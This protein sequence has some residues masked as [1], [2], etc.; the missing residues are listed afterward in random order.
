MT[1]PS[2]DEA[3]LCG[4]PFD[5]AGLCGPPFDGAGLSVPL[6]GERSLTVARPAFRPGARTPRRVHGGGIEPVGVGR[7][8]CPGRT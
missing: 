2:Y 7:R 8:A 4:P 6:P 3:G 1:G 5:G